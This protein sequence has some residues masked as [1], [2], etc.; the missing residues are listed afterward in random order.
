MESSRAALADES[1]TSRDKADMQQHSTTSPATME[2]DRS[3]KISPRAH[4]RSSSGSILAK[5]PFLRSVQSTDG[6][7]E[8]DGVEDELQYKR[9]TFSYAN[10]ANGTAHQQIG[11]TSRKRKGSLRKTALLGTGSLR[12]AGKEKKG[13][14]AAL[15]ELGHN[16]QRAEGDSAEVETSTED[17]IPART[18]VYPSAAANYSTQPE[19]SK[20]SLT[21]LQTSTRKSSDTVFGPP[22]RSPTETST[23]DEDDIL[24]FASQP[25]KRSPSLAA[26][27]SY[28]PVQPASLERR[29]PRPSPQSPLSAPPD[30]SPDD[31]DYSETESWGWVVLIVTWIV[32]V[33]GMGSCFEVWSWA[34]DVGETPY[35]PPELE[36]DPTLP[37]VGYY[38]ALIILTAV[39]AWVWVVVAW[40]GMKYFKHAKITGEDG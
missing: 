5:L 10:G 34:W 13:A 37:I 26:V 38:P 16:G 12:M 9:E 27:D 35:A 32:F 2:R 23:T 28:F 31:W 20:G 17:T 7:R 21:T 30:V 8:E 11:K 3:P 6:T 29:R 18:F 36:D 25:T 40:L 1:A 39:M 14:A 22:V 33:V 4:K 24:T 19:Y 15:A